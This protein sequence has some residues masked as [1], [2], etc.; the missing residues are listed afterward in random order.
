MDIQTPDLTFNRQEVENARLHPQSFTRHAH[1]AYEMIFFKSGDADYVIEGRRYKLKKNDLIFTRP[2]TY[3][4]IEFQSNS[5]YKRY[6]ICF[7]SSFVG[8]R[9]LQLIPDDIEVINCPEQGTIAQIF[10]RMNYYYEQLNES[11]FI[12]ALSAML[13]EILYNMALL[14]KDVVAIPLEI[15][16][17]L[18]RALSY[19]NDNLLTLNSVEEIA[20]RLSVSTPY[21]FKLFK[22][23]LKISPKRYINLKRLHHAKR[24]LISGRKPSTVYLECGLDSYVGFYKQYLKQFGYSP[25][26]ESVS[27]HE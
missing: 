25:S 1:N 17:I 26:Q 10:N 8:N 6:N 4:Y 13:K 11:E 5:T 14:Q 2:S 20:E 9:V 12:D 21:L 23:Q 18:S 15:S 16:P 19:I 7:Q 27:P 24:M 22:Q 3:H